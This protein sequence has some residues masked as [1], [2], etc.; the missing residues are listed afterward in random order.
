[1]LLY[2]THGNLQDITKTL[3]REEKGKIAIW[4]DI[5]LVE[6]LSDSYDYSSFKKQLGIDIFFR[7]LTISLH[8]TFLIPSM[9]LNTSKRSRI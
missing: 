3:K 6:L 7:M 5:I 9:A 2:L 8:T 1:M 4:H